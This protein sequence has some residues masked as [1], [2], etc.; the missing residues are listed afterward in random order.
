MQAVRVAIESN[1]RRTTSQ[2]DRQVGFAFFGSL[3]SGNGRH[4]VAVA[5]DCTLINSARRFWAS[6]AVSLGC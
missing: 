4:R 1:R 3:L 2:S 5:S 6:G